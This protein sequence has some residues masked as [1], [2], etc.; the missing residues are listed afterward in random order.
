MP[1]IPE[2][3]Q[4]EQDID[5]LKEILLTSGEAANN[6]A[7]VLKNQNERFWALP[8]DRLLALLNHDVSRSM[9]IMTANTA[10]GEAINAQL[11][12]FGD[13]FQARIP[14]TMGRSDIALVEGQFVIVPPESPEDP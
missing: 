13:R 1:L 4:L 2:K 12:A 10:T 9:E 6:L 3:T 14:L 5:L 11:D 8:T 7:A